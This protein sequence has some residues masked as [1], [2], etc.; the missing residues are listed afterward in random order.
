MHRTDHFGTAHVPESRFGKWF[1]RSDVWARYVLRDAVDALADLIP[2]PQPAY[3]VILD[4]GCGIGHAFLFL[5][6]A[7]APDRI[8]GV[9]ID[10]AMLQVASRRAAARRI[11]F[12]SHAESL[13]AMSVPSESVDLVFCHQTFHHVVD[14]V[15]ALRE[16]RRVLRPNGVLLFAESTRRYISS[17][18]IRLLFRHPME[19][20]RTASEYEAMLRAAGFVIAPNAISHPYLWWSRPDFGIGEY[21]LGR[22]PDEP[23][24]PTLIYAAAVRM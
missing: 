7:F 24:E 3:G 8:V 16:F 22:R 13:S 5:E 6:A 17:W 19:V 23:C 20:Q 21:W 14:Q 1:L 12:D 9:D 4:A 18:L 15:A 2:S 10:R 11:D